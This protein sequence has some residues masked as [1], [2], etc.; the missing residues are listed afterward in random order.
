MCYDIQVSNE[1]FARYD[2]PEKDVSLNDAQ[3]KAF[4]KLISNNYKPLQCSTRNRNEFIFS[5]LLFI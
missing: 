3:R 5:L 2:Q 4:Q 1:E